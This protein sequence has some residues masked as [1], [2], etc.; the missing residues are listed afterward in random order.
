[1]VGNGGRSDDGG[2][3]ATLLPPPPFTRLGQNI[4]PPRQYRKI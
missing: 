2:P 3:L 4:Q 1:V